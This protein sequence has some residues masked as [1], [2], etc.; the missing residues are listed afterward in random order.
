MPSLTLQPDA[1]DGVDNRLVSGASADTNY[2]TETYLRYGID[3]ANNPTSTSVIRWNMA[4]LPAGATITAATITLTQ[5][6]ASI[7]T[8]RVNRILDANDWV[9][10]ES[11][12][13]SRKAATAWAG[14]AGCTT[15]G[16]DYDATAGAA[17]VA[18]PGAN[19]PFTFTLNASGLADLTYQ[20]STSNQGW[21][22][23]SVGGAW[24]AGF[25]YSSDH[26]TAAWRPK[27]VID[28]TLPGGGGVFHSSIFHSAIMGNTIVR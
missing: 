12:W 24:S 23:R 20:V 28:Y 16:T 4:S 14:A 9:E 25:C 18:H 13:N 21:L 6:L 3:G 11:T 19:L 17:D 10:L 7:T 8:V 27:L 5:Y 1:A 22:F 2:G 15:S 26:A